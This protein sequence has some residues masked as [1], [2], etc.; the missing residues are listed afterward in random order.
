MHSLSKRLAPG[1][2]LI[3]TILAVAGCSKDNT[4]PAAPAQGITQ[5]TADDLALQAAVSLDVTGS[6]IEAAVGSTPAAAS[7]ASRPARAQWDT[8]FTQ[9]ALTFT[10]T[11]NF[12][13]AG[14]NV[15]ADYGPTAVRMLWTSHIYGTKEWPRDTATVNHQAVLDV[16]GI[17]P[18]QDTLQFDGGVFD[19]LLNRFRSYDGT[20]TRY[21]LWTSYFTIED[22]RWLKSALAGGASWPVSGKCTFDVSAYRLRSNNASGVETH[23]Q[24]TVIVVFNGT[25]QPD[26]VVNGTFHYKWNMLTGQVTRA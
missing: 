5:D 21:F 6:D 1:L 10:A 26:V 18:P 13:D 11:R 20:R 3:L 4:N 7:G 14:G 24:A 9:G 23:Y 15:L 17:Q 19:T 22:V 8:T 25:S 2:V 12:F 16:R